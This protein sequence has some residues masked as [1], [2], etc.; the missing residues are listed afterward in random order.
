LF[1]TARSGLYDRHGLCFRHAILFIPQ[2]LLPY[3]QGAQLPGVSKNI[4]M[5]NDDF[6]GV[7]LAHLFFRA[8]PLICIP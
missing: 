3:A 2:G 5:V 6:Q 7:R 1:C 4:T 8:D